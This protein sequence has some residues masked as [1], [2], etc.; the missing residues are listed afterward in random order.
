[1]STNLIYIL[2]VFYLVILIASLWE[3]NYMRALYWLGA[4]LIVVATMRIR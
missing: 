3:K 1:M 4:M 2:L